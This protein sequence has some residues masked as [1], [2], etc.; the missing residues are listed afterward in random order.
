M[1]VWLYNGGHETVASYLRAFP[2]DAK[3]ALEWMIEADVAWMRLLTSHT[4]C[5]TSG[6][7]ST[8]GT[9]QNSR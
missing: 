6:A 8:Q 9:I 5:W 7:W 3:G 1:R 4:L 2:E